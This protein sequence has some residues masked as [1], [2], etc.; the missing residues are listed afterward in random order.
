VEEAVTEL[1]IVRKLE[2]N[3]YQWSRQELG[4][5]IELPQAVLDL[6]DMLADIAKLGPAKFGASELIAIPFLLT[7]RYELTMSNL[8]I[9]RT[10]LLASYQHTRRAI[11]TCA[12]ARRVKL[13]PSLVEVWK[14]AG[15]DEAAYKV[16]RKQF[17][18]QDTF[19]KTHALL[20]ALYARY[21]HCSRRSHPSVLSVGLQTSVQ[22]NDEATM[23][24]V[25]YFQIDPK[26]KREP[27]LTLLW[28]IDT[29]LSILRI[30]EQDVM[31][32]LVANDP[33]KWAIQRNAVEAQF[34]IQKSRMQ[35][36]VNERAAAAVPL[37]WL[38]R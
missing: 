14:R 11:E 19:P 23:I 2:E 4:D 1:E 17:G 18:T 16:Y 25:G 38:P 37:I 8:D 35:A 7:C 32:T 15:D 10:H 26:D 12:F 5:A 3:N 20:A 31:A 21:E 29:H 24:E 13:D 30:F 34:L 36:I 22:K 28:T 9:L 33:L 27:L 6:Y